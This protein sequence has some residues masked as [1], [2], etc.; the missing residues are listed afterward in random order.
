M[1]TWLD[2]LSEEGEPS[3]DASDRHDSLP[4]V[5]IAFLLF[6]R[7]PGNRSPAG[8]RKRA[9]CCWK[10]SSSTSP[11]LVTRNDMVI[12]VTVRPQSYL[13]THCRFFRQ[14][15]VIVAIVGLTIV[16]DN[17]LFATLER[18]CLRL[19]LSEEVAGGKFNAAGS[20]KPEFF[21]SVLRMFVTKGCV[22]IGR[23]LHF[24]QVY[25]S[26]ECWG[27]VNFIALL[28][29][30]H[31]PFCDFFFHPSDR[32]VFLPLLVTV[33]MVQFEHIHIQY[34]CI[35]NTFACL[36]PGLGT[37][38]ECLSESEHIIPGRKRRTS[39]QSL[40]LFLIQQKYS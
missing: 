39:W 26:S 21:A 38:G 31:S 19:N 35:I 27:A 10:T 30:S 28:L 40:I 2:V 11:P 12:H 24:Y 36:N 33:L 13:G 32:L 34:L 17:Y 7:S 20:S 22:K 4:K 29:R 37:G 18:I 14:P 25:I 9:S 5:S 6:S 16:T 1:P 15:G 8:T 23:D 3:T